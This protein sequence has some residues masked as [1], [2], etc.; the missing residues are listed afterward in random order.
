[1]RSSQAYQQAEAS[2]SW[3]TCY[4]LLGPHVDRLLEIQDGR[5]SST[6]PSEPS[7]TR[8]GLPTAGEW[9]A[10]RSPEGMRMA[11]QPIPGMRRERM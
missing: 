3:S 11:A 8:G 2:R 9:E 7:T 1:M 4:Y 10:A 6:A 5:D